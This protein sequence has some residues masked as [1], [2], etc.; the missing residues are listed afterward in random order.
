MINI[1][2]LGFRFSLFLIAASMLVV[3]TTAEFFYRS[4]Y[5]NEISEANHDIEELFRTVGAT[6]SIAAFLEDED[7]AKEAINGLVKSNKILAASIKSEALD[8]QLN[9]TEA[10]NKDTESR[11]FIVQHP[12]MPEESLAELNIYPDFDYI[13]HQAEKISTDNSYSL[14]VEAVVVGIV[15]L[16]ITYYIIISPM[17][18]VGRSLHEITPGT[19]QRIAVPEHHARSEIGGLVHDTNQLLSKVEEQF[20]QER[21]LREEIEFLEKR[22]RML[23]ENAKSATVLMTETGIIE[24]KNN[25]FIDLIEKIGLEKKQEYGELLEELF[26]NPT[27]VKTSLL[28]A[29]GRNEFAT[30]EF[31]L[32]SGKNKNAMWVQLIASPLITEEEERFYQITLNDISSRKRELQKLALQA[33]FDSLTGIY[34]RNGGEKLIA[35]LMNEGKHFALALIDLNGFKAVNDIFGHDAGDEVLIFVSDQLNDKIRKDDIAIRWGGDE[36][37]LLLQAEDEESVK[38]VISK[39]NDGVKKPFYFNS[40]TTPTIVSMSVGVAFYPNTSNNLNTLVKL[41]DIAMYKAKQNKITAPQDY[42]IFAQK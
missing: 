42:L 41:A 12:F 35:K 27:V 24:L 25:A 8:Y 4:T 21:Q 31:K 33:D 40:D 3:L 11:V 9:V 2:G 37:V 26:E 32:R 38:A 10:I 17:L 23:F 16:I 13:I 22:F 39:V 29:F 1:Q 36:F 30:G 34:N 5:E 28:D 15:A 19:T 7:L 14:Y 18:R 20:T 6:A